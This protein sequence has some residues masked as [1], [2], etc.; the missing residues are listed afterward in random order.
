V[1]PTDHQPAVGEIK[2]IL[3]PGGK[4]YLTTVRG[5]ISYMDDEGWEDTLRQFDVEERNYQPYRGG[6]WAK[7]SKK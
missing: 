6:R 2:R 3:K 7:V 5:S 1:A 4:A